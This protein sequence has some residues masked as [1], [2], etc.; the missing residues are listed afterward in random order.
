MR[1]EILNK[2]CRDVNTMKPS[3]ANTSDQLKNWKL[4]CSQNNYPN[5]FSSLNR[6]E[7]WPSFPKVQAN[8]IKIRMEEQGAGKKEQKIINKWSSIL[9]WKKE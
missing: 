1:Q 2:N 8:V 6:Y 3:L 9:K 4:C 7:A 5:K